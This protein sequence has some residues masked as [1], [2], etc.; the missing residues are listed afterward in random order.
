MDKSTR[1]LA[2]FFETAEGKNPRLGSKGFVPYSSGNHPATMKGYGPGPNTGAAS[3]HSENR[4]L[5]GDFPGHLDEVFRVFNIFQV[6][7]D[8][9]GLR[10]IAPDTPGSPGS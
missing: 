8:Y 2:D 3:E 5:L 4:F 6:T 7:D 10:V 9:P 1:R